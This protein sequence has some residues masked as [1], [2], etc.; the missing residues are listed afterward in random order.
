M[1]S[2]VHEYIW[3]E[4]LRLKKKKTAVGGHRNKDFSASASAPGRKGVIVAH[5]GVAVHVLYES[6]EKQVVRVKRRSGHVVGDDV[7]VRGERLTQLPRRTELRRRDARGSVRM[8]GAN[9]MF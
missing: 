1:F 9:L 6:G 8:V 4:I 3:T 2:R 7:I 5:H